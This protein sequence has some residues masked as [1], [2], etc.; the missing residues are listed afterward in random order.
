LVTGQEKEFEIFMNPFMFSHKQYLRAV[1]GMYVIC[2]IKLD[3]ENPT[4]DGL[5]QEIGFGS[6]T[7]VIN[8]I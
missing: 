7:S 6:T 8:M 2:T 1:L 4:F 3:E 5:A